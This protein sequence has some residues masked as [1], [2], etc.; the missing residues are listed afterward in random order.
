MNRSRSLLIAVMLLAGI[1]SCAEAQS[2]RP[3]SSTTHTA[4]TTGATQPPPTTVAAGGAEP[5]RLGE[6]D[7]VLLATS[8]GSGLPPP[9]VFQ[10]PGEPWPPLQRQRDIYVDFD[11]Q[12]VLV[13]S[14]PTGQGCQEKRPS[15]DFIVVDEDSH[16]VYGEFTRTPTE[17]PCV[18]MLGSFTYFIALDREHL[19]MEF[20]LQAEARLTHLQAVAVYIVLDD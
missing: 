4:T 13:L 18:G 17:R 9:L 11:S 6:D 12:L 1:I 5:R 15:L 7:W 19:P 16:T 8:E 2:N 14:I 10:H 20:T 3:G